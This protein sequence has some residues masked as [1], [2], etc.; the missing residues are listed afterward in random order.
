MLMIP[1]IL[2]LM[3]APLDA[4]LLQGAHRTSGTGHQRLPQAGQ[5]AVGWSPLIDF[6]PLQESG[7]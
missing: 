6:L 7:S 5:R 1:V 4:S 3:G 2:A